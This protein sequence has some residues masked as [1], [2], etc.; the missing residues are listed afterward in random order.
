[1]RHVMSWVS[2]HRWISLGAAVIVAGGVTAA[3]LT[4]GSDSPAASAAVT[5]RTTTASLGTIRQSVSST[6][7]LEP[8][9]QD[10]VNF[11]VSGTV[12]SVRAVQGDH[13]TAG[14]VLATVNS[15]AL[16]S[17][18]AQAE[19]TLASAQARV[20]SDEANGVT[21]A[22][23]SADE[24]AVSAA[25]GQVDSA[26]D[27]LDSASLRSPITGVIASVAVSVGDNVSG[28]A[29]NGSNGSN[30]SSSTAQFVVISTDKWTVT[31]SADAT[32][33]GLIKKG[34]QAQLTVDGATSQVFG[35]VSS[36]AV[37]ASSSSSGSASYPV[38]IAVTGNP[39][40]LHAGA[41]VTASIIYK[42]LT[43][44]LTVPSLALR[45]QNGK[46]VVEVS[47]D[48]TPNGSHVAKTVT[49][50]ETGNGLV[51]ITSGLK[52]GDVVF[53]AI[54]SITGGSGSR[55]NTGRFPTGFTPGGG[56]FVPG[57]G[58]FQVGQDV[59]KN[60]SS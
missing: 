6:G 46:S 9:D 12:T 60:G 50:G 49:V 2:A 38:E 52:E 26:R 13:V 57:G 40:G 44:V 17:S 45:N 29:A 48:G 51:Q 15:A 47:S 54:P 5:Y 35:T 28:G 31:A 24:A 27:E 20:S 1:M 30:G 21:D 14:Q 55:T 37:I 56:G 8:A 10:S 18:L 3:V 34:L 16:K 43:N 42:Q 39:A 58:Q 23:L 4:L 36:V 25:Q 11:A 41:S 33:I 22:Q 59:P 7:T 53:V 32:Q 19:A